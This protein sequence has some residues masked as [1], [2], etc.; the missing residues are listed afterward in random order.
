MNF[1]KKIIFSR[2]KPQVIFIAGKGSSLTA[3]AVFQILKPYFKVRKISDQNLP[4]VKDKDEI[5]IFEN[6][7]SDNEN[8]I[9][10]FIF[11]LKKSKS[12]IFIATRMG[13]MFPGKDFFASE[14]EETSLMKKIAKILPEQSSLILNFDD[15]T[16]REIKNTSKA[17][18]LTYGFQTGANFQITGLN[19]DLS[20][21]NFKVNYEG[22]MIPFWLE[23]LFG[24]EV[25]YSVL[26]GIC[27]GVI[28]KINLIEISKTLKFYKSLPGRMKL[29]KGVKNSLIL[30]DS[31]NATPFSMIQALEILGELET[32]ELMNILK[33]P[34]TGRRIAVL[35]DVLGIGK[36]TIEAHQTIGEKVAENSDL[37]FTIGA[38]ARFIAQGA[39][40]K[41]MKEEN[42]FEFDRTE[43]AKIQL[44]KEIKEND[45]ILIDGSKEM[46]MQ[47]VVQEIEKYENQ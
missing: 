5:L 8:N 1:L 18:S 21:T 27:V 11:L 4:L 42:I 47:E 33:G 41:G 12:P 6:E 3:E 34:V 26:A 17:S 31:E 36:Y 16:V 32:D 22:N 24:K 38:R 19:I 39:K 30:D 46:K 7:L 45:L 14:I 20:G 23:K 43:E 13:E 9:E 25:L 44:Q 35:G 10:K 40:E 29:I 2:K 15:E 28:K 37:L